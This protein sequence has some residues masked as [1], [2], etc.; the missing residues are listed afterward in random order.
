MGVCC[1]NIEKDSWTDVFGMNCLNYGT[2]T[3]VAK[4]YDGLL[5]IGTNDGLYRYHLKTKD[6]QHY[7]TE[8]GLADNGIATI[9]QDGQGVLCRASCD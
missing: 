8:K 2:P 5:W 9:E 1:L 6:L 4:E 7:T 3:R